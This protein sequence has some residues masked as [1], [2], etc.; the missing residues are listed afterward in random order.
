VF[1]TVV[2]FDSEN[3]VNG[4]SEIL[5]KAG[6]TVRYRCRTASAVVRA[7]NTMGGGVVI[8]G[9]R[10]P[11]GTA[12]TLAEDLG[13][14]ALCL[15]AAKQ[16]HLDMLESEDIFRI[17]LPLKG[18]QLIG[19]VNML[20]QMDQKLQNSTIP[21]RSPE[22]DELV[23]RAKELIMAKHGFSEPEAHRYLQKLSMDR[24]VKLYEMARYIITVL[25]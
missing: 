22:E 16:I 21:R 6:I 17:S 8:C 4:V 2:A 25:E 23:S 9:F 3:A 20:L 15:V 12:D 18:F 19:S 24:S 14:K 10:F 7:V 13:D 11:D 1:R 5:E